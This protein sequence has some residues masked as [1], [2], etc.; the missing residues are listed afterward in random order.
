MKKALLFTF[1]FSSF[2]SIMAQQAPPQIPENLANIAYKHLDLTGQESIQP[3]APQALT[4]I[5]Q[6][7]TFAGS[8][9]Y[10]QQNRGSAKKNILKLDNNN[11]IAVVW[12]KG[13]IS[14]DFDDLGTGYN[15]GEIDGYWPTASPDRIESEQAWHPC[16]N[17]WNGNGEIVI[18][19][20]NNGLLINTRPQHGTG[21]WSEQTFYGPAGH[22]DIAWAHAITA[23]PNHNTIHLLA[24][25]RPSIEGGTPY[26]GLDGALLY[27]RSTDG[28]Q[29]WETENMV[30][31]EI[32]ANQYQGFQP[33]SYAWAEPMGD[34]IAF[35]LGW[36]WYDQ[37]LM[38]STDGGQNWTKTTIWEHPYPMWNGQ[39]T[40]AFY[41]PDG[42]SAIALD[43]NGKAHVFFGRQKTQALTDS[44][45]WYP[46]TDGLIHWSE[47]MATPL[48]Q[49]LDWETLYTHGQL[50]GW[51][52][53]QNEDGTLSV[54][55]D[56]ESLGRYFTSL[57]CMPTAQAINTR[58]YLVFSSLAEGVVQNAQNNRHIFSTRNEEQIGIWGTP[59]H[60]L[61]SALYV[62]SETIYA[63][64]A[65]EYPKMLGMPKYAF[66]QDSYPGSTVMGQT[67]SYGVNQIELRYTEPDYGPYVAAN[68]YIPQSFIVPGEGVNFYNQSEGGLTYNWHFEGGDP[69]Y[70]T[71]E[72][73]TDIKYDEEGIFDVT[74]TV[75]GDELWGDEII[76]QDY[77]HVS[78]TNGIH[79]H[80][81][82]KLEIFPNPASGQ[83]TIQLPEHFNAQTVSV[84]DLAGN[85]VI[86]QTV[87]S[88]NERLQV[89]VNQL[90]NGI[91]QIRAKDKN[92]EASGKLVILH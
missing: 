29:S 40:D 41:C 24:L 19:H 61:I 88:N 82:Q 59:R 81:V 12:T 25:T 1:L 66:Q 72:N 56:T 39:P 68:F 2:I 34:T 9:Q 32:A 18:S 3:W 60:E 44:T 50:A 64:L 13:N 43:R 54:N 73:P 57:S 16:I 80:S 78:H 69:E 22:E 26:L 75:T 8:T 46:Y 65:A 84:Y 53:D 70:S 79:N 83:I 6:R 42:S 86:K 47:Q 27:S 14:P 31:P 87:D 48:P 20:G 55:E 49:N 58:I 17:H 30:I 10:D 37:I 5:T 62:F 52:V 23:G 45:I 76:K 11:K 51:M 21:N 35:T 36:Y 91:Y 77:I 90:A 28:G 71:Y 74:L 85:Y 33:D 89:Q 63:G 38:K 92:T 67:Q 15:N 7:E 4:A